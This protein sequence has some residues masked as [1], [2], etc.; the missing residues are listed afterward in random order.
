[1]I[2]IS[3]REPPTLYSGVVQFTVL[4][5]SVEIYFGISFCVPASCTSQ[6]NSTAFQDLCFVEKSTLQ[7]YMSSKY[8]KCYLLPVVENS[9]NV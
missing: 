1:M 7:S 2:L 9:E 3:L 4:F 5:S 6:Y 8:R